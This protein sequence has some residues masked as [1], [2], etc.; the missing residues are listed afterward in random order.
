MYALL[1]LGKVPSKCLKTLFL[2]V[3]KPVL[4]L[5]D[6]VLVALALFLVGPRKPFW[7]PSDQMGG[8]GASSA[9]LL[10]GRSFTEGRVRCYRPQP[11]E[12]GRIP[13]SRASSRSAPLYCREFF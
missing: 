2:T 12:K 9:Q 11:I 13:G 1:M 7:P 10:P 5:L 8:R 4:Y 3:S 6:V